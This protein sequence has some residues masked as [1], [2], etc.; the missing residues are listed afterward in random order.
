[1]TAKASVYK[2]CSCP[3][4]LRCRH[5]WW[6]SFT[7]EDRPRIRKSLDYVLELSEHEH[8]DSKR[9]A[10]EWAERLRMGIRDDQIP[11][12]EQLPA[13][14]RKRL[15]L[16]PLP[17]KPMLPMLTVEQ[18]LK[19]YA[20]RA[21]KGKASAQRQAYQI[22]AALR[23]SI[24]RPTGG[25]APLGEWL[26]VDVTLDTLEQL[27]ELRSVR[28]VYAHPGTNGKTHVGGEVAADRDLRVLRQAWNWAIH[29]GYTERTPFKRAT[30]TVVKLKK[31]K[32]RSRRLQGAEADALLQVCGEWLRA[33]VEAAIETG[34]REAELLGLQWKQVQLDGAHPELWLPADKTKTSTARR[35]PISMRLQAILAMRR[36]DPAG[37]P[38]PLEAFV[39]GNRFGERVGSFKRAW[40]TARLKARGLTP[41]WTESG[42]LT[43]ESRRQLEAIDLHFHDLRRE[44]GSRWMDA[45]V[46]LGT[47]Q[48][49]LG[50]ANIAQ[51]STYLATTSA[52]EHDAMRRYEERIGRTAIDPG[53]TQNAHHT[54][55]SRTPKNGVEQNTQENTRTH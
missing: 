8:I 19:Q 47:I 55:K 16:A 28:R 42:M 35:V 39:F 46:P 37:V 3:D 36:D 38:F 49:W 1:M 52:S 51:T 12:R 48:K 29:H 27:R 23:T 54:Q 15:G 41:A 14:V 43:A 30:V 20:D 4:E 40:Q 9:I 5:S 6:F 24:P 45:G 31:Q 13:A 34:C 50:H 18:L 26:L 22:G 25:A 11:G 33:I 44:A 53:L 2:I 10:E 21:L 32:A 7:P 17:A